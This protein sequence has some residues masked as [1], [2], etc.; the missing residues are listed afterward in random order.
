MAGAAHLSRAALPAGALESET[1]DA[2]PGKER[3]LKRSF[4]PPNYETPLSDLNDAITPNNR[5][6]VRWHLANIPT[7]AADSWRLTIGGNAASGPLE[8]TLNQLK[9]EF[10]P[11]ELV[12][13]C[14]CAGNRRGLVEPHVPGVEWANGAVGNARW[15]GARLKDI[16]A[17][18][19][20]KKEA[21]EIAFDGGDRPVLEATPDFVKS[22]P[23]WKALDDNTLV[24]YEM[25]GEPLPH[26]NG[27][28]ARI[29]VPGWVAT[30]WV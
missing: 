8:L 28:P 9:T 25:N 13:V 7:V 24:A 20:V 11:I 26:W 3:L 29:I 16:L 17:R 27:F 2:L 30:Y 1:L 21:V 15:K 18:A 5:F 6:F 10:E 19:G 23:A 12:A 22:I 14:Q 4:R